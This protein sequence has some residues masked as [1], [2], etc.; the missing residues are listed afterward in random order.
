[1]RIHLE[2]GATPTVTI[3]SAREI[4]QPN[5]AVRRML[6]LAKGQLPPLR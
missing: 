3:R 4:L 6:D 2:H 5:A 1:M